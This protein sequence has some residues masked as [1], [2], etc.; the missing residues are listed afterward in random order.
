MTARGNNP[1]SRSYPKMMFIPE[2]SRIVTLEFP[3]GGL[4]DA[5][6]PFNLA[7]ASRGRRIDFSYFDPIGL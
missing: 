6:H 4:D 2:G 3:E 5:Y 1:E 7:L